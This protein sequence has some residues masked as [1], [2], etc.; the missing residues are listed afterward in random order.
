MHYLVEKNE[1]M[2]GKNDVFASVFA[3][4][5]M[6]VLNLNKVNNLYNDLYDT[7]DDMISALL[8]V[9]NIELNLSKTG[10]KNIPASGAAILIANHPTGALDGV[11]MIDI[12][13]RVR[14]D[15]KFMGNF[16]LNR[17]EPVAKYFI[18]VDPFDTKNKTINQKGIRQSI[19]HLQN[20]GLLVIFPAGEVATWQK[21]LPKIEDKKWGNPILKFIKKAN[22][23]VV[24]AWIE[25]NNSLMFHLAGK[26]NP[27][28][29][30]AMLPRELINKKNKK[31]NIRIGSPINPKTVAKLTDLKDYGNY[32][33]ANVD[34]LQKEEEEKKTSKTPVEKKPKP[35]SEII[36]PVPVDLLCQ[37]IESIRDNSY[38]LHSDNYELFFVAPDKAPNILKEIGRLRESTFRCIG[39]GT[40]Q[41][42]DNDHYDAYYHQLFIWDSAARAIVGAYRIGFGDQILNQYGIQGFYTRSLFR[43]KKGMSPYLKKTIELGR[44]FIA[45]EYQRKALP[46]LLLWKGILHVLITHPE[47]KYLL[48]ATSISGKY[49]AASKLIIANH[50]KK[51]HGNQKLSALVK[52]VNGMKKIRTTL[53]LSLIENIESIELINKLVMDIENQESAIPVLIRK[54][55]Q[56]NS[57]VLAFNVDHDFCDALDALMLLKVKEVPED[58]IK[59][60]SR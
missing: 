4:I 16:F 52:P 47:Y 38:I 44:S 24:P 21:A 13:T 56:L 49:S 1:L 50:L 35:V 54:Y 28:L 31:I 15:I 18:T 27:H 7:G 36:E 20:G 48:G 37:E 22:V 8:N 51:Y 33:R 6:R 45:K 39:E 30:T 14:Q 9:L 12:L 5:M 17:I 59:M 43:M 53:D 60:V 23:P 19:E 11:M 40:Q 57:R 42:T 25:A 3:D 10:Q 26:I 58:V 2:F 34:Y 41:E 29:R 46:L 32:L 55:L